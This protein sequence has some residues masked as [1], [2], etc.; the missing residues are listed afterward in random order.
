VRSYTSCALR[1]ATYEDVMYVLDN[2]AQV[3]R[4]CSTAQ[5]KEALA[6][7]I[8][9]RAGMNYAVGIEGKLV[10]IASMHEVYPGSPRVINAG[11]LGVAGWTTWC[12]KRA[13]ATARTVLDCYA[14]NGTRRFCCLGVFQPETVNWHEHMGFHVEALHPKAG[15][16]R[17]RPRWTYGEPKL[18]RR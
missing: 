16:P 11:F 3:H 9:R 1:E 14:K 5:D 8:L 12:V 13:L 6:D 17:S 7:S 15:P 10:A 4:N 18:Q 2:L